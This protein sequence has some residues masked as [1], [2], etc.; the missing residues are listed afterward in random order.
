MT[1][2]P[3]TS[4]FQILGLIKITYI[5]RNSYSVSLA[6]AQE[7]ECLTYKLSESGVCGHWNQYNKLCL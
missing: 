6:Y 7:L 3:M 5:T 2:T 1:E 4:D